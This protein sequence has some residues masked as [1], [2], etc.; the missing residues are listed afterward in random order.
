LETSPNRQESR[1]TFVNISSRCATSYDRRAMQIL[2]LLWKIVQAYL[3]YRRGVKAIRTGKGGAQLQDAMMKAYMQGDYQ[4]AFFKAADP[5]FTGYR[6]L[7]MGQFGAA[8]PLL[9]H[10]VDTAADPRLGALANNVLGQL[11]LEDGQYNHALE[12]FRTSRI[13]W[14][15]RGG[16]DRATA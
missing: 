1:L 2:R 15:E 12:C 10:A 7:Q 14:Q 13:L 5:F 16:A 4:T 8:L 11:L 3:D 6:L 9:Q